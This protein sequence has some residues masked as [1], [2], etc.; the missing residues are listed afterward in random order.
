M[1]PL[2]PSEKAVKQN[3]YRIKLLRELKLHDW[4]WLIAF[5]IISV[6]NGLFLR[7]SSVPLVIVICFAIFPLIYIIYE[8]FP[9]TRILS[10]LIVFSWSILAFAI[11][12]LDLT[13]MSQ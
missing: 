1:L 11:V 9:N 7:V 13:S 2:K 3:N 10:L 8:V 6:C 5:S 12:N 4:L